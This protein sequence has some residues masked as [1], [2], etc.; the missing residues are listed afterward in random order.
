VLKLVV[1][2]LAVAFVAARLLPR[3]RMPWAVPL[4]VVGVLLAVRTAGWLT[5]DS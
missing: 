1:L 2:L 4:A 5:G 3:R